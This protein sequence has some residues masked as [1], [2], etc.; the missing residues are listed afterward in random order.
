MRL[1]PSIGILFRQAAAKY[2]FPDSDLT[3]D[4]GVRIIIPTHAIHMDEKFF[5][6]PNKFKP[7]R[8][9]PENIHTI[10]KYTY[11]PFGDGPRACIGKY[12]VCG[13][14][15]LRGIINLGMIHVFI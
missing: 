7:E 12:L 1:F 2:T 13:H 14:I 5:P 6:E 9:S 8:F 11:F 15:I 4:E 3:I 10:H